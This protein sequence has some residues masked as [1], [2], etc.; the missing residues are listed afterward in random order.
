MTN[1][2]A[3]IKSRL[4]ANSMANSCN[5]DGCSVNMRGVPVP[6]VLIDMDTG[7]VGKNDAKC[8]FIFVGGANIAWVVPIELKKRNFEISDVVEQL[9]AGIKFAEKMCFDTKVQFLPVLASGR[10]AKGQRD[11]LRDDRNTISF[12][13]RKVYIERIRCGGLLTSAVK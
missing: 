10:M 4:P 13:G 12:R 8:D 5:R 6:H 2:V 3:F 1:L 9:S 11:D 7:L